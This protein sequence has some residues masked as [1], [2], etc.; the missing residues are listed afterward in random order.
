M[1]APWSK[2]NPLQTA[3]TTPPIDKDL[4]KRI[5]DVGSSDLTLTQ[6]FTIPPRSGLAWHLPAAHICRISTPEG[7]QVGDL[8]IWARNNPRER[9]WAKRTAQLQRYHAR[10]YDRLWSCLPYMRPMVTITADT[11]SGWNEDENGV[12]KEDENGVRWGVHDL[13]GT[14]C[15]PY[16]N[17]LFTGADYNY[18]C[19]SNLTRAV[20]PWGLEEGDI[21]DVINVF[22]VT[23][24]D[25]EGRYCM[26]T[27]PATKDT[28]MDLFAEQEL[29]CALSTCPGGDLSVWGWGEGERGMTMKDVCRPLKV[30]VFK[31]ND[32]VREKVLAGW[33][34]AVAPPYNGLH[35]IKV[36]VGE[37]RVEPVERMGI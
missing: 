26:G 15:D 36:P 12:P 27:C 30:E 6:S 18:Q 23:G 11:L 21:H 2:D 24:L 37:D 33:K 4:Y 5:H 25:R 13:M 34:E 10:L 17:R 19:H 29:L 8:N 7:P 32:D 22:Q 31:I 16:I 1:V 9:F 3:Y 20:R 35:G 14:R 28:Y